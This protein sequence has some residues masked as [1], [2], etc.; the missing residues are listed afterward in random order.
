MAEVKKVVK[1]VA[2]VVK[3]VA[4]VATPVKAVAKVAPVA[5]AEPKAVAKVAPVA[6]V[7]KIDKEHVEKTK[8]AI[9]TKDASKG[10]PPPEKLLKNV[11]GVAN[12]IVESTRLKRALAIALATVIPD[13]E[14]LAVAIR[15]SG[16]PFKQVAEKG[17]ADKADLLA[18]N[19]WSGRV[20]ASWAKFNKDSYTKQHKEKVDSCMAF[21]KAVAKAG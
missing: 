14:K 21:A 2:S 20:Y 9:K 17:Q 5:K 3:P 11:A 16:I 18:K 6:K 12:P 8:K 7:A 10:V 15:K 4:K 13:V 19:E 1:T